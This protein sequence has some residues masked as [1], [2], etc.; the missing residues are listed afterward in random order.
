M[1]S[2]NVFDF[3]IT[4]R[5]VNVVFNKPISQGCAFGDDDEGYTS[6]VTDKSIRSADDVLAAFYANSLVHDI[7]L[8]VLEND[9][10]D[11]ETLKLCAKVSPPR[12]IVAR[13]VAIVQALLLGPKD[14]VYVERAMRMLKNELNQQAWVSKETG[15]VNYLLSRFLLSRPEVGPTA[16]V[17]LIPSLL[18]L[19]LVSIPRMSLVLT[20][21]ILLPQAKNEGSISTECGNNVDFC[22][23]L[24][25]RH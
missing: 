23:H 21:N 1:N 7:L 16:M 20:T 5:L 2:S 8:G 18:I 14:A 12:S 19:N 11:F 24:S 4:Q 22:L 15:E 10:V 9:E 17:L 13:R 25:S 3:H 6:V